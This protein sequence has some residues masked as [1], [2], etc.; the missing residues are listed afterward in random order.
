MDDLLSEAL[1]LVRE[2]KAASAAADGSET[3]GEFLHILE[4]Y[5]RRTIDPSMVVSSVQTLLSDRPNLLAGFSNFTPR[6]HSATSTA[7]ISCN[8]FLNLANLRSSVD[9][10]NRVRNRFNGGRR[11]LEFL[12]CMQACSRG[13]IDADVVQEEAVGL[14]GRCNSDLHRELESFLPRTSLGGWSRKRKVDRIQPDQRPAKISGVT[15]AQ[16]PE[17]QKKDFAMQDESPPALL[18]PKKRKYFAMQDEPYPPP[19]LLPP[20]KRKYFAMQ[21]ELPTPPEKPKKP[22]EKAQKEDE[23]APPPEKLENA[24][25]NDSAMQDEPHPPWHLLPPKKQKEFERREEVREIEMRI[26]SLE[27]ARRNAGKLYAA[28]S[29]GR[30]AAAKVQAEKHFTEVDLTCLRREGS[31]EK[32]LDLLGREHEHEHDFLSKLWEMEKCLIE[33]KAALEKCLIQKKAALVIS[34][35]SFF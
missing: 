25:R 18:P 17:A 12:A 14:F 1:R 3:Y 29:V 16:L 19:H 6:R 11:Y 5:R 34:F 27:A 23:A 7:G 24:R 28:V 10:I 4:Q 32:F 31:G 35:L 15:A 21:E 26:A 33:K 30:V 9:F 8:E 2:V 20:K 13:E 22:H